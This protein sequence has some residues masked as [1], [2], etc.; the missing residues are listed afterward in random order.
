[1]ILFSRSSKDADEVAAKV[2]KEFGVR[3]KV[4]FVCTAH[5]YILTLFEAYKCDVSD[6]DLVNKTFETI[7]KE[8][9]PITGVVCVC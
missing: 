8:L 4:R 2:A 6:T 1:L 5:M 9:G 3:V 7:D